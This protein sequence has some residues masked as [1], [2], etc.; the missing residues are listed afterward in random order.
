MPESEVMA[1]ARAS[2]G[3]TGWLVA[4][5]IIVLALAGSWWGAAQWLH[6]PMLSLFDW[7]HPAF[8]PVASSPLPASTASK[9]AAPPMPVAVATHSP[10]TTITTRPA[11]NVPTAPLPPGAIDLLANVHLPDDA[12]GGVWKRTSDGLHCDLSATGENRRA[13][14]RLPYRPRG[15]YDFSITFARQSGNF[16]VGQVLSYDAKEFTWVM[17]REQNTY[18]GF[19]LVDNQIVPKNRTA[20]HVAPA[21]VNGQRYTS[22]VKV[23]K[24]SISAYI[25]GKL[26]SQLNTDYSNLAIGKLNEIGDGF[27][28]IVAETPTDIYSINVAPYPAPTIDSN[29]PAMV[30]HLWVQAIGSLQAYLN[31]QPIPGIRN[32][33]FSDFAVSLTPGDC[34]VLRIKSAVLH[35]SIRFAY[36]DKDHKAGFVGTLDNTKLVQVSNLTDPITKPVAAGQ[37]P[38]PASYGPRESENWRNLKLP[39]EAKPISLPE[40]NVVYDVVFTV[41]GNGQ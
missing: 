22:V 18:D 1:G 9:P 13:R 37:R 10:V 3:S 38:A 29:N 32:E 19:E 8:K 11:P 41:P 2:G 5:V 4:V 7:T 26:V 14:L 33:Q 40:A 28:G 20:V 23:R 24:D 6:R 16:L 12:L 27:L 30:S 21:L 39:E 17:G 36:V 35:R 25:D 31:G 34:I 15:E